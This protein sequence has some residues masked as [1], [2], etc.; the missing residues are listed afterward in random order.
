MSLSNFYPDDIE[1]MPICFAFD[2]N[3]IRSQRVAETKQKRLVE[4]LQ[5]RKKQRV[6][7]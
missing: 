3:D 2:P 7:H 1:R 6:D 5:S 4:E